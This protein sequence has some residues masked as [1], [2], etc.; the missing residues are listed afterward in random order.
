M[1]DKGIDL[2]TLHA[3]LARMRKAASKPPLDELAA[4]GVTIDE[5]GTVHA[6]REALMR[7]RESRLRRA[8]ISA[9]PST[10]R[11]VY[12][13]AGG[14][15]VRKGAGLFSTL[16]LEALRR[17]REK[18][19]YLNMIHA[20]R[21]IQVAR[22]CKKWSGQ[23]TDVGWRVV[24]RDHLEHD[25]KPPQDIE[26]YIRRFSEMLE[27][28]CPKYE[29]H[30]LSALLV[31]L[32][33]DFATINRPV[34]EILRS[35]WDEN[36]IVG[37]RPVDGNLI[38]PTLAW[39]QKWMADNPRFY[40]DRDPGELSAD[41]ALWLVSE[42]VGH[43]VRNA[44]Y[45]VVREG[46]LEGV[47]DNRSLVVAP[48]YNRTDINSAGYPPSYVEQAIEFVLSAMNTHEYNSAFFTRGMMAE[49]M[50]AVV[51]EYSDEAVDVF[52]DTMR[53][54]TMGVEQAWGVPIMALAD[55]N[56]I[57]KID[58]KAPN[59]DMN[60]ETWQSL[61]LSGH[62]A[63]YRMDMSEM[64][65]KPWDGG[66]GATLSTPS[67][68]NEIESA[69]EEG[70]GADLDH[71]AENVL[72]PLAQT[73]HPD[74]RVIWHHGN[75]DPKA[76]AEI[77]EIRSRVHV[78]RNE[79]RLQD[80]QR[81]RGFWL[82]EEAY[83]KASD[84]DRNR[85]D[86]NPWNWPTDAGFAQAMQQQAQAEQ[87]AEQMRLQQEQAE[88]QQPQPGESA[89]GEPQPQEADDGFGNYD[90]PEAQ[91]QQAQEPKPEGMQK[92]RPYRIFIRKIPRS[93]T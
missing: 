8:T 69:K 51:G 19:P 41:E 66:K 90:G 4:M 21:H 18:S 57:H 65:M 36:H 25:A 32:W 79:V 24:H 82:D 83:E 87:Q 26:P 58:L 61:L 14:V 56:D 76:E 20:V 64:G 50:I 45:C 7:I 49:F 68:S 6:P 3:D 30:N 44:N 86:E 55:E 29:V 71:F 77:N 33:E 52:M 88:Q 17:I 46:V 78:T 22:Y 35:V 62:A 38:W 47:F 92:A 10:T 60:Y 73:C 5:K 84:A 89:P 27:K 9:V 80:G 59:K 91:Y 43:D 37:F 23:R 2:T 70:L 34:V 16:P 72:T 42:I 13:D 74:L 39:L 67:R 48:R 63:I 40:G 28:P 54:A 75:H 12:R 85:F 31:P 1:S 93:E 53:D 81:P 15:G 11:H